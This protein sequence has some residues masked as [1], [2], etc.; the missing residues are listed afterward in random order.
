MMTT[1]VIYHP[2]TGT[3]IAADE[4][5]LIDVDD[6]PVDFDEWE[7][8]LNDFSHPPVPSIPVLDAVKE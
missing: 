4:S 7:P 6:L 1:Y 2:G 3:F 5:Y 8:Y